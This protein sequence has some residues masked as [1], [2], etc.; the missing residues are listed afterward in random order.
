MIASADFGHVTSST[1][2]ATTRF[3]GSFHGTEQHNSRHIPAS[4][5]ASLRFFENASRQII[6][7]ND[8]LLKHQ[9]FI[10][11]RFLDLCAIVF[12]IIDSF[13][14]C[15]EVKDRQKCPTLPKKIPKNLLVF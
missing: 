15:R 7:N 14:H 1:S 8:N 10:P 6:Y 12:L 9:P 11:V 13:F 4:S 3:N 5:S 2:L